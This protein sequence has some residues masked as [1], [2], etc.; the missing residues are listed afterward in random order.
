M[1][2]FKVL[3]VAPY[4]DLLE[5][6]KQI[7][8]EFPNLSLETFCGNLDHALAYVDSIPIQSFHIIL[9]RGGTALTLRAKTTLPVVS[10][11]ISAFDLLCTIR[12]VQQCSDTFAVVGYR[13]IVNIASNICEVL[14]WDRVR[15]AEINSETAEQV[16]QELKD[17]GVTMLAGDVLAVDTAAKCGMRATLITSSADSIRKALQDTMAIATEMQRC[18]EQYLASLVALEHLREGV[19]LLDEDGSVCLSNNALRAMNYDTVC[20]EAAQLCRSGEQALC[21]WRKIDNAKIEISMQQI[22]AAKGRY[23][24]FT[25]KHAGALAGNTK[26]I[27]VEDYDTMQQQTSYLFQGEEYIRPIANQIRRSCEGHIPILLVGED[28]TQLPSVA[29]YIHTSSQHRGLPFVR[30]RCEQLSQRQWE[31]FCNSSDSVLNSTSCTIYFEDIHRFPEAMQ[32][33]LESYLSDTN[34]ARNHYILASGPTSLMLALSGSS[35]SA[36]LYR[37]ISGVLLKLPP[38]RERRSELPALI[39]LC[40]SEIKKDLAANVIGVEPAAMDLLCSY[41]WPKNMDQLYLVVRRLI[42]STRGF[43]ISAESAAA[44]LKDYQPAA[45]PSEFVLNLSQPF[46]KIEQD[47]IHRVLEEENMNQTAAAERLGI[48]RSTLWRKLRV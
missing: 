30:V 29:R 39:N 27:S 10:I 25:F 21:T 24:L 46:E 8:R 14:K 38:L 13:N 11:D 19:L 23:Y 3:A 22:P 1:D 45:H 41:S 42:E 17:S 43:Y 36:G 12:Q 28:G 26:A 40:I 16:I 20:R 4:S 33:V 6:I 37:H 32:H 47:I 34:L 2:K 5:L 35:F 31:Q 9:S 7:S 18:Q 15:I 48:S 44:V